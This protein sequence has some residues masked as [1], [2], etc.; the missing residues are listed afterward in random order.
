MTDWTRHWTTYPLRFPPGDH[1]RQ[2]GKTVGGRPISEEQ[3]DRI[4]TDIER[5]LGL[6][7]NDVV[8]DLCCGNGLLTARIARRCRR[9]LGVDLSEPLLRVAERDHRPDNVAYARLPALQAARL[10]LPPG[11]RFNKVLM[12]EALQHFRTAD[13][14]SLLDAILALVGEGFVLFFGSVPDRALRRRFYDTPRRRLV[15]LARALLGRDAIGTWWERGVLRR[16]LED[17]GLEALF[18]EQS[19]ELHTSHYRF[20]LAAVP[21]I[22]PAA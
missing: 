12:Y 13:L 1:L 18:L 6:E 5:G 9:V 11:V 16:A 15:S 20:D 14:P 8:L 22:R 2:V 7:P 3:V 21:R 17:R 19:R 4:V 10:P